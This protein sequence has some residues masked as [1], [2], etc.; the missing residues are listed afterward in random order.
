MTYYAFIFTFILIT[1]LLLIVWYELFMSYTKKTLTNIIPLELLN[2]N[3][4][5]YFIRDKF[6]N[7]G[8]SFSPNSGKLYFTD[9]NSKW[10]KFIY[11]ENRGLIT[12]NDDRIGVVYFNNM[13]TLSNTMNTRFNQTVKINKNN[14]ELNITDNIIAKK[15]KLGVNL[16][17]ELIAQESDSPYDFHFMVTY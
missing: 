14:L 5:G 12:P 2:N 1:F 6:G 9:D 11:V 16:S 15:V 10:Q 17:D 7:Y 13:M 8:L 3:T 4:Q